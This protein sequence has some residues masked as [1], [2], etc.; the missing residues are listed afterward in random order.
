MA[1][2]KY[3]LEKLAVKVMFEKGLEPNFSP[4]AVAQ[5]RS[6]EKPAQKLPESQDLRALLWCSIDNDDSRDLDQLTFAQKGAS[7]TTIW[8]AIADVDALVPKNTPIDKHAQINTTSVYTPA[9]IFP[10]LPEKLSTN[11]TSLNE[12]EDRMAVVV[13]AT[14]TPEGDIIENS[15][16]RALVHNQAK[17]AYNAIGDWLEGNGPIPE[18]VKKVKGL[19][20]A[21]RCQHEAAQ[22][23]KNKRHQ[24]GALTLQS[25]DVEAK[26]IGEQ[27]ILERPL[28]NFANQL[29]E[30]FMIL[31][32]SLMAYQFRTAKIPSLRRVVRVPKYW[33]RIVDLAADL[34]E[35][36]PE[37]PN[38]K[39]LEQF[40]VKRKEADPESFPDL[41][42]S[43]IKLLGR[44]EYVVEN[45]GDA[46]LGHFGLALSE[47]THSTAPNR[48]YPDLISQRQCKA[49][50]QKQERPYKLE[51]LT[52]LAQHCTEQE[53]AATKVE[54]RMNKSAAAL[55]LRTSI[56]KSFKGIVTGA[57][58]KGTWVRL[59]EPSVEGKIVKNLR[60][61]NVGDK[62]FVKLVA[63]DVLR[64]YIDFALESRF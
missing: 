32:N 49:F 5:L 59:F 60:G 8:V 15:I 9:K 20:G 21:I 62:V 34:G 45:P 52:L 10:M 7:G 27:I 11:L 42:L 14:I 13:K 41:S 19:E 64:G 25:P 18:K 38:S 12:G 53:D 24:E 33:S 51:E 43:V 40:L 6:I 47:Y 26:L 58:E 50:L 3:D 57:S 28:P 54:R 55:F 2:E 46:P 31:S 17:L 22:F 63:V 61:L 56:G 39:A 44:G 29:I 35:F 1:A 16:F 23:L 4:E 36:L 37:D 48:R 30:E